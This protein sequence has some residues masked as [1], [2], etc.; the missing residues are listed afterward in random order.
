MEKGT[1]GNTP[2]QLAGSGDW[3]QVAEI[4]K[5]GKKIQTGKARRKKKTPLM[6]CMNGA[7]DRPGARSLR[8]P[9]G[10]RNKKSR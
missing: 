10:A 9:P 1:A 5:T 7:Q 2:G 8:H 4:F 3:V 6:P